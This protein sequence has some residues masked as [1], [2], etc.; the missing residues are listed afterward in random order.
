[1]KDINS[2]ATVQKS[3]DKA[4]KLMTV[5]KKTKTEVIDIITNDGWTKMHAFFICT[6]ASGLIHSKNWER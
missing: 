6:G 4:V 2:L 5:D 1:M 3:L